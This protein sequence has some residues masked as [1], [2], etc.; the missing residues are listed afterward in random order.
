M[1]AEVTHA[2]A[3]HR[4]SIKRCGDTK[5]NGVQRMASGEI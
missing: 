5:E 4:G 3:I 2:F 1:G